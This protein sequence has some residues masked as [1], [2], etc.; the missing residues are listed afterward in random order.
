MSKT[1]A[2]AL[3]TPTKATTKTT[4]QPVYVYKGKKNSTILPQFVNICKK[5]Q[6]ELI[7]W[8]PDVLIQCGYTDVVKS[9]G[10]IYAKGTVPVLLTAHMDT[11]H[12]E[13]MK[14]FYEQEEDGNHI[15]SSP[16]GIGGDDRCGIYMILEI[17]KTHKCSVLFC[18]DEES[19]GIGSKMF[20]NTEF[21][22]ELSNLK[23]L[24]ELDRMKSNDA[25]FY[26]CYN[27]DF[28]DF[29]L[30]NTGYKESYGSFS[31]ISYLAPACGVAAVNL[32][33]GYYNAH[34]LK[35]EVVIEEMLNTI[36]VVKK[37]LDVECEQFKYVENPYSYAYGYYSRSRYY[38]DYFDYD[39]YDDDY[40]FEH[41]YSKRSYHKV[42]KKDSMSLYVYTELGLLTSRGQTTTECWA[43]FFFEHPSVCYND[44]LDYEYY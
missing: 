31:D 25:V 43:N 14:T 34:T 6:E 18:E 3:N 22:Y 5:T 20:C 11:V 42:S 32:S 4:Q 37:L 1:T 26:D 33:C 19:G 35:E 40:G 8:L 10:F 7:E 9:P 23:Y 38:D 16:Q 39:D 17:I 21:I 12:K 2:L 15:L 30:N 13:R 24:I 28:T 41:N 36:E 44:V 29:I 27:K